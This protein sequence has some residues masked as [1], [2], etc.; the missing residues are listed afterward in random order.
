MSVTLTP[1]RAAIQKEMDWWLQHNSSIHYEQIRPIPLARAKAHTLPIY[2]DCSGAATCIYYV[3]GAPDP[4]GL[5]YSGQGFTGTLFANGE[6]IKMADIEVGDLIIVGKGDAS[7]HVYVVYRQVSGAWELF[8]HGREQAPEI[9]TLAGA[10]ASHGAANLYPRRY[11]A[12]NAEVKPLAWV[13]LNGR[14]ERIGTTQHPVR[15]A[16]KHPRSFRKYKQI[17]YLQRS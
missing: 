9:V 1:R 13:V 12:A 8:S 2:T 17:R 7:V 14:G 3:A 10:I 16:V 11:I 6:A 4:N 15:W 5:D